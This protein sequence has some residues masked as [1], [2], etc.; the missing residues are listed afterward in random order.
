MVFI[1]T[2]VDDEICFYYDSL[3]SFST[4]SY[5]PLVRN[6]LRLLKKACLG[7]AILFKGLFKDSGLERVNKNEN[8]RENIGTLVRMFN[9]QGRW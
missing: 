1:I 5:V 2:T 7:I 4:Q 6:V 9:V 3:S 8:D